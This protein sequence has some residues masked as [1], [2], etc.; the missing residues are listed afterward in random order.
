MTPQQLASHASARIRGAGHEVRKELNAGLLT[1]DQALQD[2]RAGV[3]TI[4]A[5]LAAP[6]W[7]GPKRANLLCARLNIMPTR[8]V[9]DLTDRQKRV[10]REALAR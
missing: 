5:V 7:R 10:I 3:L 6:K 8:R 4:S 9:R 1:V 2:P